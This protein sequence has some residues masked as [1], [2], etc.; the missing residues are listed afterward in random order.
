MIKLSG[1]EGK[2]TLCGWIRCRRKR[3][4]HSSLWQTG[5][6]DVCPPKYEVDVFGVLMCFGSFIGQWVLNRL[7]GW[8]EVNQVVEKFHMSL[9]LSYINILRLW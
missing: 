8:T 6:T 7:T 3:S 5:A 1:E 9:S 4:Q 2:T